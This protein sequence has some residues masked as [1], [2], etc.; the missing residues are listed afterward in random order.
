MQ[1]AAG[2]QHALNHAQRT[3]LL[4][5]FEMVETP[6]DRA[7]TGR[8]RLQVRERWCEFVTLRAGRRAR[9]PLWSLRTVRD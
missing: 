5:T 1:G 3:F 2:F 7:R 9:E 4:V 8:E 6:N